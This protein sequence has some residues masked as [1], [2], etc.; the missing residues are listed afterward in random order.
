[1]QAWHAH[2]P[3]AR[4]PYRLFALSN[5]ASLL[6]LLAYPLSIEPLLPLRRQLAAWSIAY[7]LFVLLAAGLALRSRS[8]LQLEKQEAD[9]AS[10]PRPL[11]W[12]S[13]AACASSLWLA[14][15]NHLSQEV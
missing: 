4:F 3:A 7:L 8:K 11:L 12:M 15:A 9:G 13:L 10:T 14:V 1:M 6:A 2:E 5:L